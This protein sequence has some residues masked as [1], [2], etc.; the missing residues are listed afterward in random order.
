MMIPIPDNFSE[1]S[2]R[3]SKT[4]KITGSGYKPLIVITLDSEAPGGYSKMPW[5]A[6]RQN[7]CEAVLAAGG[8]PVPVP[9]HV[10]LSE[11]YASM[12]DGFVFTGG[13]FDIDPSLYGMQERHKTVITKEQRTA[14]EWRLLRL[15]YEMQ[16]PI[17]GIC[18]GMQ[19]VNVVLGGTLIQHLPDEIPNCLPH[20]QAHCRTQAGHDITIYQ[21]TILYHLVGSALKDGKVSVNSAHHQAV[22]NLA[23][24]LKINAV[25]PDGVVEGIEDTTHPFCLGVQW[26]PEYHV[27]EVDKKIFTGLIDKARS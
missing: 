15:A 17:L 10:D 12:A 9:H 27:S 21:G 1:T 19:L 4:D 3:W 18:G 13:A 26:H 6:L 23:K 11:N 25:A 14:F 5:Y 8:V 2:D 24:G 16:K 22:K 7:Y 20:E